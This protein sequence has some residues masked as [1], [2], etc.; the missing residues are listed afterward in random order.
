MRCNA[1][2]GL[3]RLLLGCFWFG[4]GVVFFLWL[5]V[6]VSVFLK[7]VACLFFFFA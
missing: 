2:C 5:G 1:G 4:V 7:W 6:F 3:L